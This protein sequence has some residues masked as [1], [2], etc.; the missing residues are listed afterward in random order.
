MTDQDKMNEAFDVDQY[1]TDGEW[2]DEVAR[3]RAELSR[4][5]PHPDGLREAVLAW[6][7]DAQWEESGDPENPRNRYDDEPSMVKIAKAL[8]ASRAP[9][10]SKEEKEALNGCNGDWCVAGDCNA[11]NTISIL[12]ALVRRLMGESGKVKP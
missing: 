6:W 7:E 12:S 4:R 9:V 1:H 8:S 5:A 10:L 11:H 2:G 3:L